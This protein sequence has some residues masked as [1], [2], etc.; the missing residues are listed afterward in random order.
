MAFKMKDYGRTKELLDIL[1]PDRRVGLNDFY[2]GL[3]D[4]AQKEAEA[5]FAATPATP[6]EVKKEISIEEQAF[7]SKIEA[8]PKDLDSKFA[9]A[10]YLFENARH[11]EAIEQGL[12][13]MKLN[14]NWNEKAAYNLLIEIF[15]KLGGTNELVIASRKKLSK[16]LF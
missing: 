16:I 6:E 3:L 11:E 10:K 12:A 14:K 15:T 7:L 9:Y 5:N 1:T 8:D 4:K 13:I 2:L